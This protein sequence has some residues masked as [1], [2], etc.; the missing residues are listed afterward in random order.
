[1]AD[2]QVSC[3]LGEGWSASSGDVIF[4]LAKVEGSAYKAEDQIGVEFR[5]HLNQDMDGSAAVN[6]QVAE[7]FQPNM[8]PA[9]KTA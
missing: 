9:G 8:V 7:E 1:M 2:A 6:I 4:L 3:L 5:S